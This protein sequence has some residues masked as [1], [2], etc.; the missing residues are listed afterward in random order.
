MEN[1]RT[2]TKNKNDNVKQ[3]STAKHQKRQCKTTKA[4]PTTKKDNVKQH[5][6]IQKPK[7]TM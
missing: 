1:Q 4:L 7:K 6:H 5:K 2:I 3:K